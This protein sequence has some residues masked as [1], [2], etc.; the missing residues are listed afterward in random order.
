MVE[1]RPIGG[2]ARLSKTDEPK[3]VDNAVDASFFAT[4]TVVKGAMGA[5]KLVA[6]G[7]G[8]AVRSVS[9]DE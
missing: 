1:H 6:K 3:A 5:G 8:A 7:A 2:K 4:R 9:E